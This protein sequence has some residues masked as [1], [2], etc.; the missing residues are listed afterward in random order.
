[1]AV[2]RDDAKTRS[3]MRDLKSLFWTFLI[4]RAGALLS[5][6]ILKSKSRFMQINGHKVIIDLSVNGVDFIEC[7]LLLKLSSFCL[8]LQQKLSLLSLF[9]IIH[10][11]FIFIFN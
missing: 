9:R 6:I 11:I 1:M 2:W 7:F 5:A 10:I 3:G 8:Y 4:Q